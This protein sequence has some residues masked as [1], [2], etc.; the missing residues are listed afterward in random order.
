MHSCGIPK[1]DGAVTHGDCPE[2]SVGTLSA[3]YLLTEKLPSLD[4]AEIGMTALNLYQQ[5]YQLLR[6]AGAPLADTEAVGMD[7][8]WKIA[9]RANNTGG[10]HDE[11]LG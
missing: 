9:L 3:R 5:L 11:G 8:L 7:Q 1:L 6:L 10:W 2:L 4:P